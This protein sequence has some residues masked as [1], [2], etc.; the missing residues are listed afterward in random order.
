MNVEVKTY[1][2]ITPETEGNYLTTYREGDDIK[3][4]EGVK[5]VYTPAD[6]DASTVREIT[7]EEDAAYKQARDAA[8]QAEAEGDSIVNG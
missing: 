8:L 5:A 2:K 3:T 1:K 6:F 7:P 4:Y